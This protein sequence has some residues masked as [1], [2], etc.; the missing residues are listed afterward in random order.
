MFTGWTQT[1][2]PPRWATPI[3]R[4]VRRI[5]LRLFAGRRYWHNRAFDDRFACLPDEARA[6]HGFIVWEQRHVFPVLHPSVGPGRI[7]AGRS[8]HLI[9]SGPSLLAIPARQRL[10]DRFS[11]VVNGAHA[12]VDRAGRRFDLYVVTDPR[13]VRDQWDLFCA[14]LNAARAFAGD[15]RIFVEVLQRDP[16]VLVG[17]R[18]ILF[19]NLRCPYQRRRDDDSAWCAYPGVA[20]GANGCGFSA[21]PEVGVFP[22]ETVV[23]PCLQLLCGWHFREIYVFGMDLSGGRRS[24]AEAEPAPSQL[25][26]QYEEY[27]KPSL[28]LAAA[29]ARARGVA[30]WNC[31]LASALPES[32]LPKLAP[33][34][35]LGP[36]CAGAFAEAS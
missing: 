32:I 3:R 6:G 10:L 11:V 36:L 22:G 15:H 2:V 31:S 25:T 13:F 8:C 19:N 28:R 4:T 12:A 7:N 18:L 1:A 17:R 21:N 16:H 34:R 23:Y 33:E 29:A 26:R 35:A 24:Y 20:V 5:G 27:I 30:I 14:G 9:A